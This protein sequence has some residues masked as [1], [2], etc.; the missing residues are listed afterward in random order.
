MRLVAAF[1]CAVALICVGVVPSHADK[2]V[3]LV[4]GNDRSVNLPADQHLRKAVNDA[5][6]VGDALERLP[7][8]VARDCHGR[9]APS[10]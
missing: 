1:A 10:Q 8:R 6:A 5:R 3:A 4:I 9:Y 2:R 7:E